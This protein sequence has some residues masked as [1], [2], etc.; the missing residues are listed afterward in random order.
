MLREVKV[1]Y[2]DRC[3]REIIGYSCGK[4]FL[5]V[6]ELG[7]Y[8]VEAVDFCGAC[9]LS[10][11]KWLQSGKDEKVVSRERG[12]ARL[13][14]INTEAEYDKLSTEYKKRREEYLSEL[15]DQ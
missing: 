6:D 12:Y 5:T 10:Y 3:G 15:L 4:G 7:D 2:C 1:R 11:Q 9:A 8:E 13:Q 14:T